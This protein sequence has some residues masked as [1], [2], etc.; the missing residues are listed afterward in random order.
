MAEQVEYK[1]PPPQRKWAYAS[2]ESL[3]IDIAAQL[4][5]IRSMSPKEALVRLSTRLC[6]FKCHK[7]V[8]SHRIS[9][10]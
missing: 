6:I 5:G 9:M 2:E 3:E 1:N 8:V 7:V 4:N 10:L